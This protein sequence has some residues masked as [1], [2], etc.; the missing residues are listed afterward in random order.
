MIIGRLRS[1]LAFQRRKFSTQLAT[2]I[3]T[4][5]EAARNELLLALQQNEKLTETEAQTAIS[6]FENELDEVFQSIST[7]ETLKT[8]S[9]SLEGQI[10]AAA[11]FAL[12]TSPFQTISTA[13]AV[14]PTSTFVTAIDPS[15][16][17]R[18]IQ[19]TG[20]QLSDEIRQ[21]QADLQLEVNLETKRL[22][23]SDR[24]IEAKLE[25]I[26]QYSGERIQFLNSHLD[27]VSRQILTVIGG[28]YNVSRIQ[29][30]PL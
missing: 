15:G 16:L 11:A 17:E 6:A 30:M 29:L 12:S 2:S 3:S 27:R 5:L 14:L 10:N 7:H 4:P 24:Q 21:L 26:S 18:E 8:A 22:E 19:L 1:L 20:Q 9:A 23:E 25:E 28:K 13:A